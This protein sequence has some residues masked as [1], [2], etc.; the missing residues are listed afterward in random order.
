[1]ELGQFHIPLDSDSLLFKNDK[2][3]STTINN[4]KGCGRR[5]EGCGH[6]LM[7]MQKKD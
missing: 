2:C 1:M 4:H 7:M 6:Y 5:H 3:K